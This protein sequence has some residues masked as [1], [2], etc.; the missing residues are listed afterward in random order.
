[1]RGDCSRQ[2]MWLCH[3]VFRVFAGIPQ[4]R[5]VETVALV[6]DLLAAEEAEPALVALILA[7]RLAQRITAERLLEFFEIDNGQ[8]ARLAER[9]HIR[10]QVIDPDA[11]RVAPI[12]LATG[13]EDNIRP[14]TLSVEDSAW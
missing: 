3:S 7:L 10:A 11:L 4:P 5:N 14:H 6:L 1:M 9:V 13:H 12:R 2:F 8:G